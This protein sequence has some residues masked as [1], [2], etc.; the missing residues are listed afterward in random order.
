MDNIKNYLNDLK[1]L[2]SFK[3]EKGKKEGCHH[4]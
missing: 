2:I 4:I 3:S 1:T